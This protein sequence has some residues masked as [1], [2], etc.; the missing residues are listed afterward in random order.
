MSDQERLPDPILGDRLAEAAGYAIEV[1]RASPARERRS[2]TSC[3]SARC[4]AWRSRT[5]PTRTRRSP[6]CS[7]TGPEDQGGQ[8]TLDEIGRRFGPVV[9]MLVDG[10]TNTLE[11][12]KP[13]WRPR[14]EA[15]LQRLAPANR[16]RSCASRS[17]T[18]STT[19][20]RSRSISR[21]MARPRGNGSTPA[22]T[23]RPGTTAHCSRS[24][25]PQ[26]SGSRNLP[27]YR[28]LVQAVFGPER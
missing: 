20:A 14:K 21:T 11:D 25:R 6:R 24:S 17:P 18:S 5:A 16:N 7:T 8:A 3:T 4:A 15:Y 1:R 13:K 22:A 27:E 26:L 23:D 28:R 9:A 10:L 2:R 19:C 12:P